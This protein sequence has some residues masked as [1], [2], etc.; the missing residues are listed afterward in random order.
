MGHYI[1]LLW[2]SKGRFYPDDP[3][4]TRPNV[5]MACFFVSPECLGSSVS[6]S[7]TSNIITAV[8]NKIKHKPKVIIVVIFVNKVHRKAPRGRTIKL[9]GVGV[10]FETSCLRKGRSETMKLA[11]SRVQSQWSIKSGCTVLWATEENS[12]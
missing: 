3:P 9:G 1:G 10:A 7:T 11:W 2:Y 12:D 6:S 8:A 5:F 4:F